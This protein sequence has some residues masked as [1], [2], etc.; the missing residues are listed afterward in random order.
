MININKTFNKKI[1]QT[2]FK[3]IDFIQKKQVKNIIILT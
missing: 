3:N 2:Y 1:E